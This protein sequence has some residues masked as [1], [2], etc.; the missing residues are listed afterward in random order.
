MSIVGTEWRKYP[1]ELVGLY[2]KYIYTFIVFILFNKFLHTFSDFSKRVIVWKSQTKD[3]HALLVSFHKYKSQL[4]KNGNSIFGKD[5]L[6]KPILSSRKS[7]FD[8]TWFYLNS[9]NQCE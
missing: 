1:A 2:L 6:N 4:L 8:V 9:L 5:F 7:V 3:N